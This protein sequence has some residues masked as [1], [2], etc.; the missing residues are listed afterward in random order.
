M[1]ENFGN[2]GLM[3]LIV[4][5]EKISLDYL[6]IVAKNLNDTFQLIFG[7]NIIKK[8]GK[9]LLDDEIYDSQVETKEVCKIKLELDRFFNQLNKHLNESSLFDLFDNTFDDSKANANNATSVMLNLMNANVQK[10][11]N[12]NRFNIFNE[13]KGKFMQSIPIYDLPFNIKTDLHT[14]LANLE[15]QEFVDLENSHYKYRRLFSVV[16]S[17]MFFRVGF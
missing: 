16:G 4:P 3:V 13:M 2:K 5:G 7:K 12:L 15:A 10:L 17:C 11:N 1:E 8:L 9:A 6:Q 14:A